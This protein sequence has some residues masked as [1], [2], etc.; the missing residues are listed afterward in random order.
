MPRGMIDTL[1]TGSAPGVSMP[2]IG[3]ARLVIG[4]PAAV[5]LAQHELARGAEHDLLQRVREVRVRDPFVAAPRRQQ[6]RLVR[7]VGQIRPTMPGVARAS[8][9]RSTSSASGTERVCTRRIIRLPAA[10]R[11]L[12]RDPAVEAPGAQQRGVEHLGAVGRGQHDHTDVG[13]EAVHLGEDLVERLLALVVAAERPPPPRAPPD[14]V[15][16]VDEHDR[17]RRLLGLLEEVAHARG[18]HA[19]D[20]LDELGRGGREER[21]AGLAGDSA[22]EQRLAGARAAR[23]QHAARDAGAEALVALRVLQEVHDLD[24]LL[25]GLVD[26]RHVVERHG[27]LAASTRLARDRPNWPSTPPPPGARRLL[28]ARTTRTGPRAGSSGRS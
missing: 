9:S 8:R 18:A 14:R 25:L 19:H 17:R 24:E 13:L 12:H 22:R 21:H 16:L 10:V 1:R 23:Q 28:A 26:A 7:E 11:R 5:L 27:L 3:V 4:D 20:G 6:R 15:E 2:T